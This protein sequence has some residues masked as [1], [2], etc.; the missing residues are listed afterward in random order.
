[1]PRVGAGGNQSDQSNR[2]NQSNQLNRPNSSNTG[3]NNAPR[4]I[5]INEPATS[6]E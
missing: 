3:S 2:S 6:S 1:M 5:A 4:P